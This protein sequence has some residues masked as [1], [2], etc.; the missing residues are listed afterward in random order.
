MAT[1][2]QKTDSRV[3]AAICARVP[4]LFTPASAFKMFVLF[5]QGG[6][7]FFSFLLLLLLPSFASSGTGTPSGGAGQGRA[8]RGGASVPR[9]TGCRAMA[10]AAPAAAGRHRM[11][12]VCI[13]AA[14]PDA[15][16]ARGSQAARQPRRAGRGARPGPG[17][18]GPPAPRAIARA[19]PAGGR[20]V[21]AGMHVLRRGRARRVPPWHGQGARRASRARAAGA[22]GCSLPAARARSAPRASG[23]RAAGGCGAVR[24]NEREIFSA[25]VR[26]DQGLRRG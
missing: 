6:P 2:R 10:A 8:G 11:Q 25:R 20:G 1:A 7:V 19:A 23:R 9:N 26:Q 18:A 15:T 14:S 5:F 13:P 12:L 21:A 24:S 16:H 4:D 22:P 3:S 17:G